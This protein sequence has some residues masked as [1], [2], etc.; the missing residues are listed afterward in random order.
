MEYVN[1]GIWHEMVNGY[2][3]PTQVVD[4]KTIEKLCES[5]SIEE[6]GRAKYD[7]KVMNIIHLSLKL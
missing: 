1:K 3:I 5:W 4:G 7:S 2:K 6:I